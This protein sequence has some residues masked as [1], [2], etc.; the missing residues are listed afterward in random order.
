MADI[1]IVGG[2]NIDIEGCPFEDL[3]YEDSNPGSISFS[4]GG[5]GR[6]ITE[7]VARMGG[8][9]AMISV[10]GD[11]HM[12]LGAKEELDSLGVDTSR[13][14]RIAGKNSAIYLSILNNHKDMEVAICDMDIVDYITPEFL[15]ANIDLLKGSKVVALDGNLNEEILMY[16]TQRLEGTA[17]FFDPVSSTKAVR[18]IKSIGKF[19]CIKPNIMEAEALSG[20][21]IEDEA[22]LKKAGQWFI[23]RGV[24]KVFI[25]LN[26]EGVYYKDQTQEGFIKPK[27]VKINSATGAGD[28][29]SAAILMGMVKEM[30]IKEIAEYGMAAAHVTLESSHAVNKDMCNTEIERRTE[31]V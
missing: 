16:I 11:D 7:N 30:N 27:P 14:R 17:L 26:K 10:I 6:N 19:Q 4:H 3:K 2:I 21:K 15:E 8:D 24:E 31:N 29:F 25:T 22:G 9:V 13:I 5:V 23:D 18:A 1:T 28:S 12:G 20:I